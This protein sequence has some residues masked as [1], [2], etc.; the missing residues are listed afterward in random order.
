MSQNRHLQLVKVAIPIPSPKTYT[1]SL[2]TGMSK[3][4]QP[5]VRV[6]VPFG[7]R[8]YLGLVLGKT[9]HLPAKAKIKEVL[10]VLDQRPLLPPDLISLGTWISHYYMAPIG[11][12]FR[13]MFPPPLF[14]RR[15][16]HNHTKK[17]SWPTL[18]RQMITK[19]VPNMVD[20]LTPRQSQILSLISS[21]DL[22][23]TVASVVRKTHSSSTIVNNLRQ[24]GALQIENL[25]IYRSPWENSAYYPTEVR[26]HRLTDGQKQAVEKINRAL[27][28]PGFQSLLIH[29]ITG[30]GKTEIYLNAIDLTLKKNLSAL[31]LVPEISLAPQASYQFRSWFG[32]Q[33][34]IL[35]SSLSNGQRFDEWRRVQTGRARVVIGTRSAGFAPLKQL[36]IIIVDEEHDSSYKQEETPRYNARDVALK[37]G[38]DE[39][40]LVILGSATPLIETY[41]QSLKQKT[42]RYQVLRSRVGQRRLP[43][44]QIVDM[45]V[46]FRKHG[47][48]KLCSDLLKTL[49]QS[50]L[51][52]REQVLVLRN[53]RGYANT[54]L[55]RSCG[56]TK[57]CQNC[58]VS[59][60][61]HQ[62][63]E[64]LSCHYCGY[65]CSLP[66]HCLQ[67]KKKYLHYLGMGTEQ[68]QEEL[69][70]L[71]PQAQIDRLDR[72]STR[73]KGNLQ[74]ILQNF[75]SQKTDILVGT[76]MIAKGHDFPGVTLV[77]V[78]T[79]DQGL[80]LP[81]FRS[82][83]RTFQLLTQVSGRAGRGDK[84]GEVVIQTYYPNHYSL[85]YACLQNYEAFYKHEVQFRKR[86]RYPPFTAIAN[87]LVHS[88]KEEES[89][90]FALELTK[91]LIK[92]RNEISKSSRLRILG[93]APAVLYKLKGN[94]RFQ[95]ILKTTHRQELHQVLRLLIKNFPPLY[96][97]KFTVDIDPVNL[98]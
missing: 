48:E 62:N 84:P 75:R 21:M 39:K 38:S 25:E 47:R 3:G 7:T 76:Q 70:S 27:K 96:R 60:T 42:H 55:C 18:K 86:F 26:K 94:Y 67:C 41:H 1:Y 69:Q 34:A 5:G 29:G 73:R 98:L 44:V 77:G 97:K 51:E 36:G 64:C 54:L 46:E 32:E 19:T 91:S 63:S 59:L 22:P 85:K 12:V 16:L 35:H 8:H 90:S 78:L 74:S 24:A 95:V 2:S 40:A 83:E 14:S 88:Q 57:S 17:S 4:I 80:R 92:I 37:R 53:R 31:V 6:I 9:D 56:H 28:K 72:D 23:V 81:D 87:I 43:S 52:N 58:S 71:Y 30:S 49:I 15:L 68:V 33:V 79:A 66:N 13:V 65:S 11:E 93:P 89:R 82:A 45:R 20:S 61:Y 10:E 50:R